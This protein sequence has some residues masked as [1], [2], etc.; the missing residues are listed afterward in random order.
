[1]AGPAE[2]SVLFAATEMYSGRGG[3][4]SWCTWLG[5]GIHHFTVPAPYLPLQHARN[6]IPRKVAQSRAIAHTHLYYHKA[7]EPCCIR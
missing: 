6:P 3:M 1:M 2:C 7:I 5:S 4:L